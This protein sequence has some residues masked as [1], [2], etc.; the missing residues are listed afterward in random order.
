[1]HSQAWN[2]C[3]VSL[4][5]LKSIK[6]SIFILEISSISVSLSIIACYDRFQINTVL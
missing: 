2:S 1:M 3:V 6:V 4:L 5:S